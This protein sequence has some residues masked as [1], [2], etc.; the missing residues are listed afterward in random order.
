MLMKLFCASHLCYLTLN[1]VKEFGNNHLKIVKSV[2]HS[3]RL[4]FICESLIDTMA[5]G[6]SASRSSRQWVLCKA[7]LTLIPIAY[8]LF[9]PSKLSIN[10]FLSYSHFCCFSSDHKINSALN[11]LMCYSCILLDYRLLC[12]ALLTFLL[13][14]LVC[15]IL[16]ML[17]YYYRK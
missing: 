10:F 3:S 15:S 7:L 9:R 8:R 12:K 17:N 16:I 6:S 2:G 11:L 4:W 1:L 14:C 5:Y 13:L